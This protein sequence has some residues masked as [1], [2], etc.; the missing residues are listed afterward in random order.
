MCLGQ[1]AANGACIA[2]MGQ[3]L[4]DRFLPGVILGEG[5]RDQLL[6]GQVAIAIDLHQP[7]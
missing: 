2:V 6:K 3:P 1:Q 4:I 7:Q 5:E